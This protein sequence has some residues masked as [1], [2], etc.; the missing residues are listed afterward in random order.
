LEQELAEIWGELLAV[1]PVGVQDDFFDIGGHSLLAVKLVSEIEKRTGRRVPLAA[2][3]QSRTIEELAKLTGSDG[4]PQ[5]PLSSAFV[6]LRPGTKPPLFAA[7]SHPR[8]VDVARRLGSQQAFYRL[9]VYGLQNERVEAGAKPFTRIEDMAATYVADILRVQPNGPYYL[10]GGCEGSYVAFEIALQLQRLGHDVGCLVMWLAPPLRQTERRPMNRSAPFRLAR[11]FRN[12][13]SRGSLWTMDRKSI[14]VL[15]KH[16]YAEYCIF[17]ALDKYHPSRPFDG[18][19]TLIRTAE[20]PRISYDLNEEWKPLA[21]LGIDVHVVPG[22]HENWLDD[23]AD[24]F[25]GLLQS[26][27]PQET[28]L[29]ILA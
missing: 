17:R 21:T 11:Q 23:H 19:I 26:C 15:L 8:Y 6:Q 9:D 18:R 2:L 7:G 10:G 16:E 3:F 5:Q 12:L 1:S 25:S 13:V 4:G 29:R 14:A 28:I 22:N 24:E 20:S 27:L